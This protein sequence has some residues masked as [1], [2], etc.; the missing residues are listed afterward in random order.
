[1]TTPNK[2]RKNNNQR[3]SQKNNSSKV[4]ALLSN[5]ARATGSTTEV[6]RADLIARRQNFNL[7]QSPP[8]N[9]MKSIHWVRQSVVN[10]NLIATTT[11][12]V[13]EMN[14]AF[15]IATLTNISSYTSI[16]DQYCIYSVTATITYGT[17]NTGILQPVTLYTAIDYDN[18]TNT[19]VT[20]IQQFD[21][22]NETIITPTSSLVR[23]IKPCVALAA[24]TGAFT[25]YTTSRLW[26][27]CNS[28]T[29][30]HFGLR[31]IL[32]ISSNTLALN[33]DFSYVIGF[34]NTHG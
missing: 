33:V 10:P 13:N 18:V 7:V 11:T 4:D 2:N 29:V 16:F 31:T 3:K 27:D 6:I 20:G 14:F 1:M 5:L 9:F 15:T 22:F 17:S 34:R 24:Y 25:G 30:Q 19:G 8:L 23:T 32:A 26:I 21:S 28:T 12:I